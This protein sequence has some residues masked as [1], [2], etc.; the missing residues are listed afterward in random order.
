VSV[1]VRIRLNTEVLLNGTLKDWANKPPDLFRDA[2]LPGAKPEPWLIAAMVVT[3]EAV[4]S[5]KS[6]NIDLFT[7]PKDAWSMEVTAK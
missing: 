6:I 2:I 7:W 3:A 4:K 5:E 1:R